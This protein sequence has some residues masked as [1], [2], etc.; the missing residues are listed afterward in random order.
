MD[1]AV[2]FS[3]GKDS[4]FAIYEA[5]KLGH[6]VKCLI[7]ILTPSSESHL[8]HHPNIMLASLQAE[9]MKIPQITMETDSTD[10]QK[11]LELLKKALHEAKTRHHIKGIVHG[12]ILSEFQR[13]RFAQVAESLNLDVIAPLWQKDQKQYMQQLIEL[14]FEF[15]ITSVSCNGLD[16]SWLGKRITRDDL[17]TLDDLSKKYGFNLSFEGGEAETFVINCPLFS[18]PIKITKS[19]TDWDGC[20]GRFQIMQADLER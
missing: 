16:K 5:K 14:G 19:E 20:R 8:L 3:G 4:T 12:G 18:A 1:V 2:L 17:V 7:T 13:S 9:S 11:E 6:T 10:T 15:I